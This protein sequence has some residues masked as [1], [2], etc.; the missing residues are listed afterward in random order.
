MKPFITLDGK[1]KYQDFW[2][3][4]R[5]ATLEN[6]Q[7]DLFI[8]N[9][10]RN[11]K[12]KEYKELDNEE[13]RILR[14]MNCLPKETKDLN[15]DNKKYVEIKKEEYDSMENDSENELAEMTFWEKGKG[16]GVT[17]Y[18]RLK[19]VFCESSEVKN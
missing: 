4:T 12:E 8:L 16:V 15:L 17:R 6:F 14:L 2:G 3:Q 13:G 18:F 19:D 9:D 11:T 10:I 7:T 5:N 1:D